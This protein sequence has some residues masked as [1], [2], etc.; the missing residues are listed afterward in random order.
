M[1]LLLFGLGLWEIVV[2]ALL[3]LLL[4]GANKIPELM[5]GIGR[6]VKEF[7]KGLNSSE[8]EQPQSKEADDSV[9]KTVSHSDAPE[10]AASQDKMAE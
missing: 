9:D 6:G 3:V 2:I 7:K 5:R 10:S 1:K 8:D 4:F